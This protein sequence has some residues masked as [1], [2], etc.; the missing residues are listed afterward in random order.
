MDVTENAP[1]LQYPFSTKEKGQ[2]D[3]FL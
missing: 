3:E 1:R 2:K